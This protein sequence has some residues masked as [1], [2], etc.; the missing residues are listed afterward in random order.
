MP[1]VGGAPMTSREF[2]LKHSRST[3]ERD[4][5]AELKIYDDRESPR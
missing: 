4:R 5:A 1:T 2:C 3:V